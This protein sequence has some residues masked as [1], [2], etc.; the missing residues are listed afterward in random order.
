MYRVLLYYISDDG[1]WVEVVVVDDALD[2]DAEVVEVKDDNGEQVVPAYNYVLHRHTRILNVGTEIILYNIFQP[3]T[4][5]G[6][7][8]EQVAH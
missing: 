1:D 7:N 8:V 5:L 4:N 6:H 2:D 3:N